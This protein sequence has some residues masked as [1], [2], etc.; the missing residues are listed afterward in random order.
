V[1]I[2]GFILRKKGCCVN[3]ISD[4]PMFKIS[5]YLNA[6]YPGADQQ[7]FHP[8]DRGAACSYNNVITIVRTGES[9]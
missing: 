9:I 3:A 4:S 5:L 1:F 8:I 2:Y 6:G 7:T